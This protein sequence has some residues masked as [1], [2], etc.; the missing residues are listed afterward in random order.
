[1]EKKEKKKEA[2]VR[3]FLL[4]TVL[5]N[6]SKNQGLFNPRN[7]AQALLLILKLLFYHDPINKNKFI[8]YK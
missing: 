1:M 6:E 2:M 3:L 4:L 5:A 7:K 8:K